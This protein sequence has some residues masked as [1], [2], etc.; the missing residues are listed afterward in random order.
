MAEQFIGQ[1][2]LYSCAWYETPH[3]Y[4]WMREAK[5]AAAEVDYVIAAGQQVVPV[6]IKAGKTGTLK[7]LHRFLLEKRRSFALRF[8]GDVP[9]LV[10]GSQRADETRLEFELLS[11]PLYMVGQARRLVAAHFV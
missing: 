4:Y 7:S 2:L 11:L 9:S 8:N 1:H 5:S 3:L 6:E 10:R